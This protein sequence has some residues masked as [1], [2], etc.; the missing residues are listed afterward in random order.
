MSRA[1]GNDYEIPSS[2]LHPPP[3]PSNFGSDSD[4]HT[5]TYTDQFSEDVTSTSSQVSTSPLAMAGRKRRLDDLTQ[6]AEHA[7]RNVRLKP[8]G[9]RQV[10]SFVEACVI[11]TNS[12]LS[13]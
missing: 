13:Y 4:G 7:A 9:Y 12:L 8:E 10:L 1:V 11:F 3:E 2:L 5:T 6:F